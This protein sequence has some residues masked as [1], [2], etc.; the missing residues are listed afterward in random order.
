MSTK[1]RSTACWP[2]RRFGKGQCYSPPTRY[3]RSTRSAR[4]GS[5]TKAMK[6]P[7]AIN[8][9]CGRMGQRLVAL[10]RED[11]EL[12]V[13][14]A[15]DSPRHPLQ[16]RDAGEVAGIGNIDVPITGELPLAARVERVIDFSAPPGTTAI[17]P[18][19]VGRQIPLVVATTA[20][21]DA[22]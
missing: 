2:P 4:P 21:P 11:P 3:S 13:A 15:V 6:T 18:T 9:A 20:H 12:A 14:A 5:R 19:C 10:A 7:I 17:L 1:T 8:G 16:G 22:Q